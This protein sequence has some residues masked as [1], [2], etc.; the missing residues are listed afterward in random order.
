MLAF[1]SSSTRTSKGGLIS[2]GLI[3]GIVLLYLH[4]DGRITGR[5]LING[6]GGWV[7]PEFCGSPSTLHTYLIS[8]SQYIPVWVAC[9]NNT[10]LY[11]R[12]TL[13]KSNAP[14]LRRKHING[15]QHPVSSYLTNTLTSK[16]VMRINIIINSKFVLSDLQVS[17]VKPK[18]DLELISIKITCPVFCPCHGQ[19]KRFRWYNENVCFQTYHPTKQTKEL[20]GDARGRRQTRK[21]SWVLRPAASSSLIPPGGGLDQET[22]KQLTLQAT[23]LPINIPQSLSRVYNSQIS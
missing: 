7:S 3:T 2:G 23:N 13:S 14:S 10:S 1:K 18:I 22:K 5:G 9:S 8:P 12:T 17:A 15:G 4:I 6:G 19:G 21:E 16:Q 11:T 20:K